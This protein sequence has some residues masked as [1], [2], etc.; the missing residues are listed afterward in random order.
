MI[1]SVHI[2]Q[3]QLWRRRED[4][5]V[6]CIAHTPASDRLSIQEMRWDAVLGWVKTGTFIVV[7]RYDLR[8]DYTLEAVE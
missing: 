8:K 7:L 4:R 2:K 6:W 3:G 1:R 5:S